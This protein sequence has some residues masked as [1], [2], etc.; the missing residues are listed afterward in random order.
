MTE[1]RRSVVGLGLG[2]LALI[3][4]CLS[5]L[6]WAGW[7]SEAHGE[8]TAAYL[9]TVASWAVW[10]AVAL[11]LAAAIA[12]WW[13]RRV[14]GYLE[15][16]LDR[17]ASTSARRF[18]AV[19]GVVFAGSAIALSSVLFERNPHLVDTIAQLFQA[20]IFARGS[21]TAP[22]PH[23]MEFFAA[24]HLVTHEGRWFSQYPPGQPAL[25][26]IG[27]L[28]GVPWLVNPLIAAGTLLVLFAA[29]RRLLGEGRA[30]LS[31]V[32]YLVS[33][34]ALF[35]SASYM[36]HVSTGFFLALALYAA[37][38]VGEDD[39]V[40]PWAPVLG[41]AL[42]AA[43][44]VRPLESAAWAM[45]LGIWVLARRG[46]KAAIV[47]A[48]VCG[49]GLL[50]LLTYN[51]MTTGH[52]LRFG[53]TLLWGEGHG[54]G[55][56]T[57]PWGE[58]FTPL[59]SFVNSALDFQRLNVFLFEWPIPS[60][61]FA[62]LALAVVGS[63]PRLRGTV[64]LLAGLALAAPV[65]YFFYWHR[66]N[67]LGPRFLFASLV[68]VSLLTAVGIGVVDRWLG[69]WRVAFRIVF[70]A[71]MLTALLVSIPEGAGVIAGMEPEMKAH[72]EAEAERQGVRDAVVFVKTGWGSRL[73]GRM[74]GWGVSAP[75]AEQSFR[76]VDGCRIQSALDAADSLVAVD[77]DSAAARERLLEQL[78]SWRRA[79]LPLEKGL[80]PDASVRVDTTRALS[81]R[82]QREIQQDRSGF[83]LYGTLVWH[84][85]PWLQRG[86]VFARYLEPE[87][88]RRLMRRYGGREMYLYAPLSS[89]RGA[90]VVLLRLGDTGTPSS[91]DP[92]GR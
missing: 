23:E 78:R 8:E 49:V 37:V 47:T 87:R 82:C 2:L 27:W 68:P 62:L 60:L 77:S 3:L 83:T 31:V 54:L 91:Q 15:R 74:W 32:L 92:V 48:A 28:L 85:D 72:P 46:W 81:R 16:A 79:T 73:V 4:A 43:A 39:R 69:R 86:L 57:D 45:V 19:C 10:L 84:N 36:N 26:A 14:D 40:L 42:A 9:D 38:R 13:G 30:R 67:Y 63:D 59:A 75:E 18:A 41:L 55:F 34:F 25:L 6:P 53:Y 50:P 33:P 7:L 80:L 52:P 24:S 12:L 17:I 90:P 70:L 51:G 35:M 88:N 11:P 1:R 89:E 76:A 58:P 64:A 44:T 56:H 65:A 61:L 21:L 66:D 71:A 20:R 22:A 29:A 5:F